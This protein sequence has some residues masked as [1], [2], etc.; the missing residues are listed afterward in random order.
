MLMVFLLWASLTALNL[1]L[2]HGLAE[3]VLHLR[4]ARLVF[5]KHRP[6]ALAELLPYSV[7][8]G[9]VVS[10][11][12]IGV[13]M[14]DTDLAPKP[15]TSVFYTRLFYIL[16][17]SKLSDMSCTKI[18]IYFLSANSFFTKFL[19]KL[20]LWLIHYN[21]STSKSFTITIKTKHQRRIASCALTLSNFQL[22]PL[23]QLMPQI[24]RTKSNKQPI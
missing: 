8:S 4:P 12:M 16:Y 23:K 10:N 2:P 24:Y 3:M 19:H 17:T 5:P 22:K 20:D 1:K 14:G 13:G 15:N 9:W 21:D 11:S 6:R 7:M 18:E